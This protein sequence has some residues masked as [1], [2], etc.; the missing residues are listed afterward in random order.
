MIARIVSNH[1]SDFVIRPAPL[2]SACWLQ[3]P[4]VHFSLQAKYSEKQDA[5]ARV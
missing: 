5:T 3:T 1:D 2:D 4:H